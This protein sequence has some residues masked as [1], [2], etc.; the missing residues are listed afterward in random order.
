MK[1]LNLS[2][3]TSWRCIF[4]QVW[5]KPATFEVSFLKLES[6]IQDQSGILSSLI[7]HNQSINT[8]IRPVIFRS[9]FPFTRSCSWEITFLYTYPCPFDGYCIDLSSKRDVKLDTVNLD[10]ILLRKMYINWYNCILKGGIMLELKKVR[11]S[12]LF[13]SVPLF[14]NIPLDNGK[15]W[16]GTER[17]QKFHLVYWCSQLLLNVDECSQ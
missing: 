8:S 14:T 5:P 12:A 13:R 11:K 7:W 1:I 17:N 15:R 4:L 16:N 6:G 9:L 3:Y 2:P 10:M